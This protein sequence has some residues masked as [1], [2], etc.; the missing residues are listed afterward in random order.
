MKELGIGIEDDPSGAQEGYQHEFQITSQG[1]L[2]NLNEAAIWL[3]EKREDLSQEFEPSKTNVIVLNDTK[4]LRPWLF[5]QHV[6]YSEFL[7]DSEEGKK[8]L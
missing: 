5:K 2:Y 3:A 7:D 6:K 4:T 1:E 8:P